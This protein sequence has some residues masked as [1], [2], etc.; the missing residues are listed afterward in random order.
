VTDPTSTTTAL[1]A[2][3]AE[4]FGEKVEIPDGISGVDELLRMASHVSHRS[5]AATPVTVELIKLLSACALSA[6]TKSYLQQADIVAVRDAERRASIQRLVPEMPWMAGA[7]ALL[8]FCG[9]GRRFKRLFEQ[10]GLPFTNDNLDGFFNAT[11]DAAMVMMNFMAAAS[12]IGLVSCP[13]SMIRNHAD[14]LAEILELP[15][16]VFPVAAVCAGYPAKSLSINP[17]LSLEATFHVDTIG[18]AVTDGLIE[19]FDRRY[20]A[21]RARTAGGSHRVDA[22]SDERVKQYETP[23]RAQWGQFVRCKE[24]ELS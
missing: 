12:A 18:D 3:L 5:W 21:V 6:P 7:P 17:R 22:W 24:F 19:E 1:G 9:D 15:E 2:A 13:V 10:R 4:R 16:R 23:Q 14:R 11:V 20:T 8:V